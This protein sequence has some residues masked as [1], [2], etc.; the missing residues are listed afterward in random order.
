MFLICFKETQN[1]TPMGPHSHMPIRV[2]SSMMLLSLQGC[3]PAQNPC[4]HPHIP[5]LTSGLCRY[6]QGTCRASGA[7]LRTPG[8]L[9]TGD[10]AGRA[11]ACHNVKMHVCPTSW[12]QMTSKNR[13]PWVQQ[14]LASN[15]TQ[16]ENGNIQL[17]PQKTRASAALPFQH[18]TPRLA[19]H[20]QVP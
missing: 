7:N 15:L 16:A 18:C 1:L 2:L 13:I 12:R 14:T 9:G 19:C 4:W 17:F 8:H 10:P 3:S 5:V 11:P 20:Q 6:L